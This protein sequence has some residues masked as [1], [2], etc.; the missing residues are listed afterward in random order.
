[1][2]SLLSSPAGLPLSGTARVEKKAEK[3]AAATAARLVADKGSSEAM[4]GKRASVMGHTAEQR[5]LAAAWSGGHASFGGHAAECL[6]AV[7]AFWTRCL[8]VAYAKDWF[9]VSTHLAFFRSLFV[10]L[11]RRIFRVHLDLAGFFLPL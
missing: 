4:Q 11:P 3:T 2:K 8:Y 10:E 7:G 6:R 5:T 1:M 9:F